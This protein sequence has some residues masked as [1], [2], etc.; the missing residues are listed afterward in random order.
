MDSFPF[1]FIE[2]NIFLN[3]YR[4][5]AK[6]GPSVNDW[7]SIYLSIY[8]GPMTSLVTIQKT[9]PVTLN[10]CLFNGVLVIL[11]CVF[12]FFLVVESKRTQWC[13]KP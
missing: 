5:I 7:D 6:E 2:S 3:Y 4:F 9:C 1:D 8:K 12:V 13:L 10:L 11:F